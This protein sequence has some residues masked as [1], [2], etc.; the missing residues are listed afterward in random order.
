M[1]NRDYFVKFIIKSLV[2]DVQHHT[3]DGEFTIGGINISDEIIQRVVEEGYRYEY[4]EQESRQLLADIA[5]NISWNPSTE[6]IK[7]PVNV[8]GIGIGE[9]LALHFDNPQYGSIGL[10]LVCTATG[11]FIVL[12]S[13]IP[14]IIY[15][16]YVKAVNTQWNMGNYVELLLFR[17]SK[18]ILEANQVLRIGILMSVDFY[19]PSTVHEIYDSKSNYRKAKKKQKSEKNVD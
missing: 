17:C 16:D 3:I 1:A 18:P 5:D 8:L 13:Q 15:H 11:K 4:T 12:E 14:G 9:H 2:K 10:S 6:T 7:S 19:H